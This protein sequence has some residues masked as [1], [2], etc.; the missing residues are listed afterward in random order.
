MSLA[1]GLAPPW[2]PP[3]ASPI[4]DGVYVSAMP[5]ASDAAVIAA[6]D[7]RLIISLTLQPLPAPYYRP[8]FHAL[9]LRWPDSPLAPLPIPLLQRGVQAALP[10][11]DAG[12]PVLVH[13]RAGVHRSAAVAACILVARGYPVDEAMR[14]VKEGRPIADPYAWYVQPRIR[15]FAQRWAG[16][17][18]PLSPSR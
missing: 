18:A 1:S 13:C 15:L 8:P 4:A 14:R 10:E 6:L 5:R 3:I 16:Q 11:M 17:A 9:R 2:K 7:I 12:H